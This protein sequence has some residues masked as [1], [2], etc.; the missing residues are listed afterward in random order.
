MVGRRREAVDKRR[1]KVLASAKP[2]LDLKQALPRFS[3]SLPQAPISPSSPQ[4]IHQ[5]IIISSP[6]SAFTQ[7]SSMHLHLHAAIINRICTVLSP[8][9]S[10][11]RPPLGPPVSYTTSFTSH[12]SSRRPSASI[13]HQPRR[14]SPPL[15]SLF[16]QFFL[17]LKL[18]PRNGNPPPSA[19]PCLTTPH[20]ASPLY[21]ISSSNSDSYGSRGCTHSVLG[22]RPFQPIPGACPYLPSFDLLAKSAPSTIRLARSRPYPRHQLY[23]FC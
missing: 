3:L 6:P 13:R 1:S 12:R 4:Q 20:V 14:L 15:L 16:R 21:T 7:S 2:T 22:P 19:T 18:L 8:S 23:S 11:Y 5:N 9:D 17:Q 10:I